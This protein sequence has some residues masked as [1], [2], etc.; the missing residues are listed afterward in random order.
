MGMHLAISSQSSRI[1]SLS[2]AVTFFVAVLTLR[3]DIHPVPLEKNATSAQCLE[4]HAE[5][6]KGKFVHTAVSAGCEVRL[7]KDVTRVKLV[8]T[9]PYSL[10]FDLSRRQERRRHQGHSGQAG[11]ARLSEV[12][13]PTFV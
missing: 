10:W 5:K 1:I 13:Q 12:P 11:G 6:A 4:C 2:F 3:A 8:T 9:A 7:N